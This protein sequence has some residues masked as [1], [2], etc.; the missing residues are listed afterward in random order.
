MNKKYLRRRNYMYE[1]IKIVSDKN[2]INNKNIY[3]SRNNF[4]DK[5][6]FVL[7]FIGKSKSD[8]ISSSK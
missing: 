1:A 7:D 4:V 8:G 3:F 2:Y 5:N 6:N